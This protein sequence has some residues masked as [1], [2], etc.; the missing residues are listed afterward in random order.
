MTVNTVERPDLVDSDSEFYADLWGTTN[1]PARSREGWH[2]VRIR[3]GLLAF[4]ALAILLG[5]MAV[6]PVFAAAPRPELLESPT[7]ESP[8][9][10]PPTATNGQQNSFDG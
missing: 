2:N 4:A 6:R 8:P 7:A 10:A 3:S 5:Y 1:G 9:T